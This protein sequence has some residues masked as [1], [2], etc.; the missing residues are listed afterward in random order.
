MDRSN[1]P[2]FVLDKQEAGR[3]AR[4]MAEARTRARDPEVLNASLAQLVADKV[5]P[6]PLPSRPGPVVDSLPAPSPPTPVRVPRV[7]DPIMNP[8][9]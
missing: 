3:F 7:I 8:N 5:T 9:R 2:Q 6:I 1:I 4:S